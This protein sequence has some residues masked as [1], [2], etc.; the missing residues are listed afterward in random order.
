MV[1]CFCLA[2]L[3]LSYG[4]CVLCCICKLYFLIMKYISGHVLEKDVFLAPECIH[5]GPTTGVVK[6]KDMDTYVCH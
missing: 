4:F 3:L 5:W 1:Y 2:N 6:V